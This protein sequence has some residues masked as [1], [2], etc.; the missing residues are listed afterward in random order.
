LVSGRHRDR[1]IDL[2][3]VIGHAAVRS[4]EFDA[5]FK[6]IRKVQ[7]D[8]PIQF[9]GGHFHIR[10]YKK[11]D[12][13]SYGLASGRFMETIGF[14]SINGL[15]PKTQDFNTQ[16]SLTFFRRY[17]D[18]NLY[19][20][21]H[22]SSHNESSFHSAH[23]RKVSN[24]IQQSRSDLGLDETFGCAPRDLWMSRAQY[25]SNNSIFTWLEDQVFPEAVNGTSHASTARL[26]LLNTGAIRFDVFKGA[27]TKD[28]TYIVSPFTSGFHYIPNVPY[29]KAKHELKLLNSGGEIFE[30]LEA[31]TPRPTR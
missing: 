28:S 1:N 24:I 4:A 15:A 2:F 25:P 20:F 14:Q 13:K 21:Y 31:C 27:F 22:H 6:E 9:F 7:W 30:T 17:I 11:F 26:I 12:S 3:L 5:I 18:N 19:S 16:A 8:V 29:E 23:G 10:D